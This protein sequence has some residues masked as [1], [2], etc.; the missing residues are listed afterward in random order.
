MKHPS[1]CLLV[2]VHNAVICW[3]VNV[4]IPHNNPYLHRI[5]YSMD[6]GKDKSTSIHIIVFEL[7]HFIE[8]ETNVYISSI[9]MVCVWLS[10][11][12]NVTNTSWIWHL[13]VLKFQQQNLRDER[14]FFFL[15]LIAKK[16]D[17]I[18]CWLFEHQIS[19]SFMDRLNFWLAL[20]WC[21]FSF[22]SDLL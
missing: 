17:S 12:V 21:E 22:V 14:H 3:K 13:F 6:T 20:G 9:L 7:T 18:R 10:F 15:K 1:V 19:S 5:F 11:R 2:E 16:V 8:Q 4:Y